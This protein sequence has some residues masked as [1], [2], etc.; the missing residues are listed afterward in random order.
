MTREFDLNIERV[1]ENWTVAHALREDQE[2]L[3]AGEQGRDDGRAV[4]GDG[5]AAGEVDDVAAAG[6]AGGVVAAHGE[7]VLEQA[8]V[9][10][11]LTRRG[12]QL[13]TAI[14]ARLEGAL[15]AAVTDVAIA[16]IGP[17]TPFAM[18]AV[19]ALGRRTVGVY[20]GVGTGSLLRR[21]MKAVEP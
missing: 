4:L 10:A 20:G 19:R 3:V 8:R 21:M 7:G 12:Q 17:V 9:V 14:Q 15:P 5:P 2:V 11:D 18:A 13:T 16:G 6:V 1:L